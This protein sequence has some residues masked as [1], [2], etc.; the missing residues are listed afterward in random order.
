MHLGSEADFLKLLLADLGGGHAEN[1]ETVGR[2]S[3]Q[4]LL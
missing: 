2:A 1:Y 4:M 3:F